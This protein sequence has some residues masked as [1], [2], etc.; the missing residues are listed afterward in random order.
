[1]TCTRCPLAEQG[2]SNC[3]GGE[4]SGSVLLVGQNPGAEEDLAERPF[5]GASGRLLY[6][7]LQD[8]GFSREQVRVT[9]AVRCRTPKNI[10]PDGVHIGACRIHLIE[11]V[12]AVKPAVIVALGATALRALTGL[13]GVLTKRGQTYPLLLEFGLPIEVLSTFH[14]AYVLRNPAARATV[15]SDLRRLHAPSATPTA[16]TS[17]WSGVPPAVIAYDIE[18]YDEEGNIT[19]NMTQI[20]LADGVERI[21]LVSHSRKGVGQIVHALRDYRGVLVSHNGWAFDDLKTG[22]YSTY[23][24]MA[25]GYLLDETQSLALE[26]LCVKYLGVP[27]W[28]ESRGTAHLGS[29]ELRAYNARDA[30]MTLALFRYAV[31]HLGT[32]R[33]GVPRIRIAEV[34]LR[35]LK[36]ALNACSRKGIFIQRKVVL[37]EFASQEAAIAQ[38]RLRIEQVLGDYGFP[39]EAFDVALKTKSRHVAFNP[40]STLHVAAVLRYLGFRLSHT[41]SGQDCTDAEALSHCPHPFTEALLQWREA[42]KRM[43]T[44]V[45]PYLAAASSGDGRVHPQYTLLR[46]LTGRTSAREPNVQNLDRTLKGFFSAPPGKC[47][48]RADYEQ[49]EFWVAVWT[50][51]IDRL[52]YAK[53]A[54]NFDPHRWFAAQFYRCREDEVTKGQRQIAKSANFA[55]LYG[56]DAMTLVHYAAGLGITLSHE[57]AA[58]VFQAFHRAYPEFR[59]WH[60][61]VLSEMSVYGYVES[62]TGRRRHTGD[63]G[64]LRD[65]GMLAEAH[66]EAANAL[67]QGFATGDIAELGLVCAHQ[68]GL[69]V[70]GFIHDEVLFEFDSEQEALARKDAILNAMV[71]EP[72]RVL[73]EQFKVDFPAHL[74][75]VDITVLPA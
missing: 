5:V 34:I 48:V 46:T 11:E 59:A 53:R 18:T 14:P 72:L 70:C 38:A 49:I 42:S 36:D 35:P 7:I 39:A 61:R 1:M 17:A 13:S 57:E 60:K 32:A 58:Q 20:A 41:A 51:G 30:E 10:E 40:G 22:L 64:L 6:A 12:Q 33:S 4:G 55:L 37:K 3:I 66:R 31:D 54:G 27:G 15:V 16:Y 47:L 75:G 74:L 56:G 2:L 44:Y 19:E 50:A 71:G 63:V 45:K 9:N 28:K 65:S 52:I 26:S 68:A 69:P 21:P 62:P 43:S 29:E 8:A 67:V 73:R 23:D 25:L 24:T